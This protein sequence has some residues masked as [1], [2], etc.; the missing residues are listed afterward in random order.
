MF[1]PAA[2]DVMSCEVHDSSGIHP[3]SSSSVYDLKTDFNIHF[4]HSM[5]EFL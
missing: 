2:S 4:N 1:V 5:H 3:K